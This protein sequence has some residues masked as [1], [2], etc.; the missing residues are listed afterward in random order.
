MYMII[1]LFSRLLDHVALL[2]IARA[3]SR[4]LTRILLSSDR[5]NG[6]SMRT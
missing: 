3:A 4:Q 6:R 5:D 2:Y 1:R